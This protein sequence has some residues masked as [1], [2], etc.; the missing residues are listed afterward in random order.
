MPPLLHHHS[1]ITLLHSVPCLWNE[2]TREIEEKIENPLRTL[3]SMANLLIS[4]LSFFLSSFLFV[5]VVIIISREL[6]RA[7]TE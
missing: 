6:K 5:V 7:M 1:D 4:F 2:K 3:D